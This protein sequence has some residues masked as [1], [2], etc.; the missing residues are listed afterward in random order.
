MGILTRESS[1]DSAVVGQLVVLVVHRAVD[2]SFVAEELYC[3]SDLGDVYFLYIALR[4]WEMC[5][6]YILH[7]G[8]G[9]CVLF[10]YCT[11]DLG[12]KCVTFYILKYNRK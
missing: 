3:T 4:I 2:V 5:T 9:K 8:S 7:F 1:T 6:F 10:I 12:R 11:A